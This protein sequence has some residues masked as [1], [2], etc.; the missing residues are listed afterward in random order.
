MIGPRV[1]LGDDLGGYVEGVDEEVL[2][3][4]GVRLVV[5]HLIC[6]D[7]G[8]NFRLPLLTTGHYASGELSLIE[9]EILLTE[10]DRKR[11]IGENDA[12]LGSV[13]QLMPVLLSAYLQ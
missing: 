6:H 3:V 10:R 1:F 5:E 9:L 8:V 4:K 11:Q 13:K 12:F 2:D 7:D